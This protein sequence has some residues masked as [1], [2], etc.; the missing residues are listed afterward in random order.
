MNITQKIVIDMH[1]HTVYAHT[2]TFTNT[3]LRTRLLVFRD[4][5]LLVVHGGGLGALWVP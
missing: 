3:A 1:A 2:A 4:F 5:L